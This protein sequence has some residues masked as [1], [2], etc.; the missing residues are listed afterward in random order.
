MIGKRAIQTSVVAALALASPLLVSVA[1]ASAAPTT[2]PF[3]VNPQYIGDLQGARFGAV[4]GVE[5]GTAEL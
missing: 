4:V 2:I 1:P 5:P 3:Q